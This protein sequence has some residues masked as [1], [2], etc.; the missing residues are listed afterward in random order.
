MNTKINL[1]AIL[2]PTF[3][4]A[5]LVL[6]ANNAYAAFP[7]LLGTYS[8][9]DNNTQSMCTNQADN[10][11]FSDPVTISITA[12]DGSGGFGGSVSSTTNP[13]S[14]TGTVDTA[15]NISGGYSGQTESGSFTG[16]I[17]GS[18]LSLS[19]SG[20]DSS[21]GCL[22]SG[23]VVATGGNPVY[24]PNT[25]PSTALTTQ[26]TLTTSVTTFSTAVTQ[27]LTSLRSNNNTGGLSKL[28]NGFM[29]QGGSG[30]SS[31]DGMDGPLGVWGSVNY[32]RSE[33][34]FASTAFDARRGTLMFGADMSPNENFVIGLAVGYEDSKIDTKFN[35]GEVNSGGFTFI[36][37]GTYMLDDTFSIDAIGGFSKINADQY[38]TDP[39]TAARITSSSDSDRLFFSGNLNASRQYDNWFVTGRAGV[40][41]AVEGQEGFTESNGRVVVG[42][43]FR[44]GQA[45]LGAEAAYQTGSEWE[46]YGSL[47]FE[48]DYSRT[49]IAVAAG[50]PQPEFDRTGSTLGL[51]MRYFARNGVTGNLE[52]SRVLGR[53]NY[54]E[55]TLNMTLR[56]EF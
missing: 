17:S 22:V 24:A 11:S 39:D 56:A 1:W 6:C 9:T 34:D 36:T 43:D 4:T 46:P 27:R 51:G 10:G 52:Y 7:N 47:T 38:R 45:R 44:I 16:T 18:T 26:Q 32:S 54:S 49:E 50:S 53:S 48:Y 21:T 5:L 55:G 33:D 2:R 31:G 19:Y 3:A 30:M 41:V 20:S 37:Y 23:S 35:N 12:Q 29:L 15:G 13:V 25:A 42:Q 40:L 28:S 8:G 14:I